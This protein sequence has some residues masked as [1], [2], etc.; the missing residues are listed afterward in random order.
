MSN[1]LLAGRYMPIGDVPVRIGGMSK[2]WCC[3]DSKNG[4]RVAV[5]VIEGQ[6]LEDGFAR[7][8]FEREQN[9][10]RLQHPNIARLHDLGVLDGSGHPFL[11]F[12][13]IK[14]D[15]SQVKSKFVQEGADTFLDLIGLPVLRALCYAHERQVVH[16]DLKPSN[17]LVN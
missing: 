6:R 1:E 7:T 16:R 14:Y 13:W 10:A 15:L 3:T 4:N 12:D 8:V 5:K 9:I 2:V 11:V 17:I